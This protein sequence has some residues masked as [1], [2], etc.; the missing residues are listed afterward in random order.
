[1]QQLRSCREAVVRRALRQLHVRFYHPSA[2]R[3][4]SHL[5]AAG[6]PAEVL[7]KVA[8]I[9]DTCTVCR[10]WAR[11][12]P[13][14]VASSHLPTAFNAELQ[15]DLLFIREHVILHMID[16][17]TR[18]VVAKVV[19][20]R[21]TND[22][23]TALQEAWVSLFGPPSMIVADQEGALSGVAG[24]ACMSHRDIKYVPKAKYAHAQ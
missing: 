18:F 9:T 1:M 19:P 17:A 10:T 14:S 7:E 24:G 23:L 5:S 15:V 21:E 11:P 12:G 6:V 13:K 20:S 22:V 4:R 2:Q 8:Q 16:V 3:L